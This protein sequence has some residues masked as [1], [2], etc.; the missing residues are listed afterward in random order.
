LLFEGVNNSSPEAQRE[1]SPCVDDRKDEIKSMREFVEL[2][3]ISKQDELQR[4]A[5]KHNQGRQEL[6]VLTPEY[7]DEQ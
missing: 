2:N 3:L 5:I 6:E 7:S 1:G 4:A